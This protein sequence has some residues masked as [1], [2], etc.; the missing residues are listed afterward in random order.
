MNLNREVGSL[1]GAVSQSHGGN[2]VTLGCDTHTCTPS[3]TA[4]SLYL[5]PKMVLGSLHLVTLRVGLHLFHYLVDLLKFKVN[6]VIHHPLCHKD[7]FLEEVVVEIRLRCKRV[8]H[9]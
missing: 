5:L 7:M 2:H 6:D 1:L 3:H 9:V 4:L 8:D